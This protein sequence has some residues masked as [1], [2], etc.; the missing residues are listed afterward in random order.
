M[1]VADHPRPV[2]NTSQAVLGATLVNRLSRRYTSA[3]SFVVIFIAGA[4]FVAPLLLSFA[5]VGILTITVLTDD[6][7]A[8]WQERFLSNAATTIIFVP[9]IIAAARGWR[10]R[11]RPRLDRCAVTV[12]AGSF[13]AALIRWDYKGSVGPAN[14]KETLYRFIAPRA[15][16]VA[17]INNR[18]ISAMLIYNDKTKLGKLLEA[19]K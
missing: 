18:H 1:T 12:P 3:G 13:D 10:S 8:A 14:V 11:R 9:P 17:M 2:T 19:R 6:Y 15:G 5:D 4:V 16:M 7:W